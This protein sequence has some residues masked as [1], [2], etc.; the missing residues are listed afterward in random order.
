MNVNFVPVVCSMSAVTISSSRFDP[1]AAHFEG[2]GLCLDGLDVLLSRLVRRLR[3]DPQYELVERHHG[4]R[5][6]IAPVK[7]KIGRERDRV[8]VGQYDG[9]LIRI[10]L[11]VLD[12]HEALT[13][14]AAVFDLD[15]HRLRAQPIGRR[16]P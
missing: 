8:Q 3:V 6:R 10:A 4:D 15:D 11:A 9:D 2:I 5:R 12:I 1:G 16:T 7:R 14:A 13:A